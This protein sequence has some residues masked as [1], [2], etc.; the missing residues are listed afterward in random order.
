[1]LLPDGGSRLRERFRFDRNIAHWSRVLTTY[2]EGQIALAAH[3]PELLSLGAPDRRLTRLPQLYERLLHDAEQLDIAADVRLTRAERQELSQL[4][5]QFAAWCAELAA[6]PVPESLNHGDLHDG[7]IFFDREHTRF[8]DWGDASV[9]HPFVSMRTVFVSV[10]I[11]LDLPDGGAIDMP[12]VH[13]YLQ[14]W[15]RFAAPSDLRRAFR[16]AQSIAPIV[17]ALSWQRAVACLNAAQVREHAA[18]VAHL[19]RE[20]LQNT[21]ASAVKD[22]L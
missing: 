14:P 17:S 8:F 9:A 18:A 4:I 1:M 10:E 7:N 19:L 22:S 6:V 11:A 2:A 13:A 16:R 15:A 20:F 12:F 5:P 21:A 3:V